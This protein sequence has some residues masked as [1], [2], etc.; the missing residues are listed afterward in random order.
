MPFYA[1]AEGP[2]LCFGAWYC[3]VM[4]L[5]SREVAWEREVDLG[6]FFVGLGGSKLLCC[7]VGIG[8]FL[9]R[10]TSQGHLGRDLDAD[11]ALPDAE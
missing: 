9:S 1:L 7:I 11:I 6:G 4:K 5:L 10:D 3:M 8:V 2:G